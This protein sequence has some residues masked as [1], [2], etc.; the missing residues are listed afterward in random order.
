MKPPML[1]VVSLVDRSQLL[2]KVCKLYLLAT[3]GLYLPCE[4]RP[5]LRMKLTTWK[6]NEKK[7]SSPG[8]VFEKVTDKILFFNK[9]N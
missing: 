3:S 7:K 9:I 2:L 6:K 8:L 1:E 5:S 4:I